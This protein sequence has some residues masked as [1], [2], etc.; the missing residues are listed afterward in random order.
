MMN[1]CGE[2]LEV[3]AEWKGSQHADGGAGDGAEKKMRGVEMD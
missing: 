3:L 2:V 1:G